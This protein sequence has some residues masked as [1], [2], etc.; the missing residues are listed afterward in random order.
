MSRY[1]HLSN[2]GKHDLT[3]PKRKWAN[4]INLCLF[5]TMRNHQSQSKPEYTVCFVYLE[6]WCCISFDLLHLCHNWN[7]KWSTGTSNEEKDIYK[8]FPALNRL[9]FC[10]KH[11]CMWHIPIFIHVCLTGTLKIRQLRGQASLTLAV[12]RN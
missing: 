10:S 3:W 7:F 8:G 5:I 1:L 9:L 4:C 12:L 6:T 2:N 11:L